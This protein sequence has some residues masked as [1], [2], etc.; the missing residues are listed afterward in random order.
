MVDGRVHAGKFGRVSGIDDFSEV[1]LDGDRH[2]EGHVVEDEV[3]DRV[4]SVLY[5]ACYTKSLML[6]NAENV[7]KGLP[8]PAVSRNKTIAGWPN[9]LGF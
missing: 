3:R 4:P 5:Q 2:R 6:Y 7:A 9:W 8:I 1:D